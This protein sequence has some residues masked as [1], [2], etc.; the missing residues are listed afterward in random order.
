MN[1][2]GQRIYRFGAFCLDSKQHVLLHDGK[3]A[4][5]TPKASDALLV[6][7]QNRGHV[8]SRDDLIK[9]VWPDSFVEDANLTV[10]ISQLR[11]VLG[12]APNELPLIET[13]S[14]RGYRFSGPVEEQSVGS[15]PRPNGKRRRSICS[16]AVLPFANA[17][18]DPETEYLS[19]GITESLIQSLSQMTGL[20]VMSWSSIYPFKAKPVDPVAV[21]SKLGVRAVLTGRVVQAG[22]NLVISVELVNARDGSQ[23]WGER[24]NQEFTDILGMQ[25]EVAREIAGHLRLRL[26]GEDS[27]R[28]AKR[29]TDSSEA[30]KLYLK[31]RYHWN[32]RTAEGFRKGIQY[33]RQACEADQRYAWAYAGLADCHLGLGNYSHKSPREAY[34]QAQAAALKALEIDPELTEASTTLAFTKWAFEWNWPGAEKEFKAALRVD[35]KYAT[36]HQWYA[37]FLLSMGKT[38]AALAQHRRAHELDPLSLPINATLGW[39]FYLARQYDQAADQ[40]GRTLELDARFPLAHLLLGDVF[41]EKSMFEEAIRELKRAARSWGGGTVALARLAYAYA[42]TGEKHRVQKALDELNRLSK[43]TYV[44]RYELAVIYGALGRKDQAFESLEGAC[45]E[46]S[47]RIVFLKVDPRMDHLRPDPQFRNILSR[48]GPR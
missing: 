28:L 14:K 43:Q 46:R 47:F 42:A 8:V 33:F 41:L 3:P 6:L 44:S 16:L 19:D 48:I 29:P 21:G 22:E 2:S 1:E 32:K 4:R 11:K 18:A 35:P 10:T 40:L 7:L 9:R 37:L 26:T 20:K 31:G 17:G 38:E 15:P 27:A 25:E 39:A 45:D 30:Y 12:R 23:I 34:P 24:Y 5:L 36:A 13:V